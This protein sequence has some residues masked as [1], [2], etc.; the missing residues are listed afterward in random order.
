MSVRKTLKSVSLHAPPLR[1]LF[2]QRDD[3]QAENRALRAANERLTEALHGRVKDRAADL[4]ALVNAFE[5]EKAAV[6]RLSDENWLLRRD[7]D[8]LRT[9][10]GLVYQMSLFGLNETD[11]HELEQTAYAPRVDEAF[12][13]HFTKVLERT[14]L[15]AVPS[16]FR[17]LPAYRNDLHDHLEGRHA[18]FTNHIVP[19]LKVAAGDTHRMT[20][21]EIGSGTGA[22][23][24]AFASEVEQL[25]CFEIDKDAV[26]AARERMAWFGHDNVEFVEAPFGPSCEFVQQGRRAHLVV[27]CAVLEHMT[28]PEVVEALRTAWECL[29]PGGLMLIADTPNRFSPFDGHTAL[30][31]LFSTLPRELKRAYA[32]FS[33]RTAFAKAIADTPADDADMALTR[34]G[35]GISFHEFEVALGPQIHD[36]VVLDGYEPEIQAVSNLTLGDAITRF[37]FDRFNVRAHRAFTRNNLYFVLRKP[38]LRVSDA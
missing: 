34:W 13:E 1:R 16:E 15:S 6:Q 12:R 36:L 22:S 29:E 24:L 2:Q 37:M 20:A 3:A 11:L 38:A 14:F 7:L 35:S 26:Q 33:P 8:W 30:L 19:W 5:D 9:T 23:S 25:V 32:P 17:K 28:L 10:E 27:L 18:L 4:P 21:I 31:P